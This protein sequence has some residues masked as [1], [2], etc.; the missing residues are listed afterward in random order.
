[1]RR[2]LDGGGLAAGYLISKGRSGN[3]AMR[4][5]GMAERRAS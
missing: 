1:M 2:D 4:L 5:Y 3:G